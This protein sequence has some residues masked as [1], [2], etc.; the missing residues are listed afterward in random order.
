[1]DTATIQENNLQRKI[2]LI[3][4]PPPAPELEDFDS[5]RKEHYLLQLNYFFRDKILDVFM[6]IF[7]TELKFD[8]RTFLMMSIVYNPNFH[9]DAARIRDTS[10]FERS[11]EDLQELTSKNF[12]KGMEYA[13]EVADSL[14]AYSI[15]SQGF[16]SEE[17]VLNLIK[18]GL[19]LANKEPHLF[20]Y[21]ISSNRY[22]RQRIEFDI[23][24]DNKMFDY[25]KLNHVS[26]DS[27]ILGL[28]FD[29]TPSSFISD[30]FCY[31]LQIDFQSQIPFP[32][33]KEF[34]Q[35]L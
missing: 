19:I 28:I 17:E 24:S 20:Y 13:S 15:K 8:L 29:Y 27:T 9:L 2:A 21:S 23:S 14:S 10:L 30:D 1:M 12:N 4:S 11:I 3:H 34:G 18:D 31:F 22:D 33:C 7:P 32:N 5:D 35:L 25:L 6:Q 26:L 16:S